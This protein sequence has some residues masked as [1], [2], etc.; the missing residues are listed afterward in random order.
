M[1]ALD[2]S[3]AAIEHLRGVAQREN[4]PIRAQRADLRTY[5]LAEVFDAVVCIGLLMFFDCP[6]A[7]RQLAQPQA[8][9]RPGGHAIVDVLIEGTT[10]MDMFG[11][12]GHCLFGAEDLRAAFDGWERLGFLRQAFPAPGGASKVFITVTARKPP[13][14]ATRR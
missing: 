7:R 14:G 3:P 12:E 4:L 1:L 6:T 11:P 10:Y 9:V 5:E 8:R 2:A 13:G